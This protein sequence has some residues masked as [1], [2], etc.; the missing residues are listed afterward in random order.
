MA[1]RL[2]VSVLAELLLVPDCP[3]ADAARAVL[4]EGI[5]RLA[6]PVA[7][8]ER[9]GEYPSP[10]ILVNGVDVVTGQVFEHGV[11]A[12]RLDI[13]TLSNVVTALSAAYGNVDHPP[14]FGPREVMPEVSG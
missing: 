12:C 4:A 8:Q 13:P 2:E 14:R 3:H 6:T 9:V 11:A 7:V 5:N 1:R 10:T